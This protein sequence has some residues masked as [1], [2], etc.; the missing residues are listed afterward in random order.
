MSQWDEEGALRAS[1]RC[2]LSERDMMLG[3][4]RALD[5]QQSGETCP[6]AAGPAFLFSHLAAPQSPCKE[7]PL[8]HRQCCLVGATAMPWFVCGGRGGGRGAS[9]KPDR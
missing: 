7:S 3:E 4:W 1:S 8:S 5:V 6:P 9:P 2:V